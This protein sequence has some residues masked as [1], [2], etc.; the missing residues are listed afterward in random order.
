MIERGMDEAAIEQAME[1]SAPFMTAGSFAV[2]A[3]IIGIIGYV[4]IG[5]VVSIFT[6]KRNPE[7]SI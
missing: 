6:Q 3:L 4:I 7:M 5:L 1:I 2:V